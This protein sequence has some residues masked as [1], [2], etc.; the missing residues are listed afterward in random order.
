VGLSEGLRSS[1]ERY[2]ERSAAELDDRGAELT[3]RSN[4]LESEIARLEA[5]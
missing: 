1:L 5:L 4:E 2:L 3:F